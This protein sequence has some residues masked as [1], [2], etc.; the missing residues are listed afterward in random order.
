MSSSPKFTAPCVLDDTYSYFE[1]SRLDAMYLRET[2][3]SPID[4]GIHICAT[5]TFNGVRAPIYV[6]ALKLPVGGGPAAQWHRETRSRS[7]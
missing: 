2:W 3:A 5:E 6:L 1:A 7:K 4:S